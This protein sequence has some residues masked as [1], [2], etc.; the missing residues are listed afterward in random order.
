MGPPYGA[1]PTR[2]GLSGGWPAPQQVAPRGRLAL[3]AGLASGLLGSRLLGSRLLL[4]FSV[5]FLDFGW[6]STF[7]WILAWI[8]M[9]DLIL[10]GFRFDFDLIWILIL[11]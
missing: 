3:E 5:D 11:I 1:P 4:S 8:L 10:A 6:I 9:F 7:G 2:G